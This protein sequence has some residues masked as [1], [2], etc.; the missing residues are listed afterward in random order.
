MRLSNVLPPLCLFMA[1]LML[2]VAFAIIAGDA[3]VESVDI[4]SAR[5]SGDELTEEALKSHLGSQ[6][7]FRRLLLAALFCGSILMVL[8]SFATMRGKP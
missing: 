3:P 5:A 6:I 2:I 7:W 1:L 8:V 4:H